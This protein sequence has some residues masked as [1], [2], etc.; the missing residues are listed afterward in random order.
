M[1]LSDVERDANGGETPL[2][3]AVF[4]DLMACLFGVFVLFFVW[5][6]VAQSALTHDLEE[7]R[8]NSAAAT[9]RLDE[10]ERVLAGP[11]RTGLVTL[12]DGRIGI[13]GSVLFPINSAQIRR[14]GKTLL[15]ELAL[16]LLTYLTQ[17]DQVLMVSGFTDD[18]QL[19]NGGD[20]TDNWE[21][22]AQ[23]SLTVTREL[24]RAGLPADRIFAAGFGENQPI[25]PNDS[26][27]N[28]ALNRRVEI[29]PVPR[30][31][32]IEVRPTRPTP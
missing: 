2:I 22:S 10:L 1:H 27:A 6:V 28:R 8:A 24:V 25:A 5:L 23:R 4:G 26:E 32:A 21:L 11:L 13:R 18:L 17:R 15:H 30:P 3:Y 12:V 19:R 20:F 14:E 9:A 31:R 16:P 7:E 29:A